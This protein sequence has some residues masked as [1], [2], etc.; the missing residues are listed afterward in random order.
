MAVTGKKLVP[1]PSIKF[2]FRTLE[3]P[4]STHSSEFFRTFS[5]K[6]H[7]CAVLSHQPAQLQRLSLSQRLETSMSYHLLSRYNNDAYQYMRNNNESN[8]NTI[9]T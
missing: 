6:T 8:Y 7:G 3:E 9:N 2:F 1:R 5:C 4:K